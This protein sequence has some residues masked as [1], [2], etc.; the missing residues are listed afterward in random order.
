[1]SRLGPRARRYISDRIDAHLEEIE[2]APLHNRVYE[3]DDGAPETL[4]HL[5]TA[6]EAAYHAEDCE[7]DRDR[8]D[9]VRAG[10]NTAFR[11]AKAALD[12]YIDELVAGE[13]LHVIEHADEWAETRDHYDVE[14]CEAAKHEA[15]EWLQQHTEAADRA[16]VLEALEGRA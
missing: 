13:C 7:R 1:M 2:S 8:D 9:P 6:A 3:A 4:H 10:A 11:E 16:G 12:A 14:A 15:R 5:A